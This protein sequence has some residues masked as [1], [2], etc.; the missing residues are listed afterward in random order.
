MSEPARD[1]KRRLFLNSDRRSVK[2]ARGAERRKQRLIAALACMGLALAISLYWHWTRSDITAD[3]QRDVAAARV[4]ISCDACEKTS[5]M[6]GMDFARAV[7]A[8][9]GASAIKCPLCGAMKAWRA[10]AEKV[11]EHRDPTP[12]EA[13]PDT[14]EELRNALRESKV[15]LNKV[16][17]DIRAA[18][19]AGDRARVAELRKESEKVQARCFLLDRRLEQ[20]VSGDDGG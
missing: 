4:V 2:A 13:L 18:D 5:E 9:N 19:S 6:S 14:A 15:R 12:K 1:R 20:I 10:S 17:E 16:L 7:E 8:A 3:I 11:A